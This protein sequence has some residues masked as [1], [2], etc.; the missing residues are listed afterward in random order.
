M[1]KK[2]LPAIVLFESIL[3]VCHGA[4]EVSPHQHMGGGQR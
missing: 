4:A 2:T 1:S 3:L